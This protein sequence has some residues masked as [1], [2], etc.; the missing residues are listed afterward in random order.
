MFSRP[1][2]DSEVQTH[3]VQGQEARKLTVH[4]ELFSVLL[5]GGHVKK[6]I[7][8]SWMVWVRTRA[9]RARRM[10]SKIKE[11]PIMH[12]KRTFPPTV[13]RGCLIE[14]ES[15][16]LGILLQAEHS[17]IMMIISPETP[18]LVLI[19]QCENPNAEM[20]K[21]KSGNLL[22]SGWKVVNLHTECGRAGNNKV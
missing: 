16:Q 12:A 4:R 21:K 2:L 6:K 18:M 1:P 15:A 22:E 5:V 20:C 7:E 19:T 8:L 3:R 17:L 9:L 10:P 14:S 13:N 11:K